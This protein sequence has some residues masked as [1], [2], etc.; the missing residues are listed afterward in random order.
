M[1]PI[2][3]TRFSFVGTLRVMTVAAVLLIAL[4]S[5]PLAH[6]IPPRVTVLAFVKPEG[7]RL[8]LLVRALRPGQGRLH[9]GSP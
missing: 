2:P 4:P 3:V 5:I 6:E 8:R 1:E 9:C 7:E